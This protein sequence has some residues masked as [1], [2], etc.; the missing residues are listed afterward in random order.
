MNVNNIPTRTLWPVPGTRA[1][2]IID[3]T[4]LPHH[5]RTLRLSTLEE[6]TWRAKR[7]AAPMPIE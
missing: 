2:D 7:R 3:Q 6:S 4:A 1:V 5:F